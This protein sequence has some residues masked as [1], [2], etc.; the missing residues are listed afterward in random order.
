MYDKLAGPG[1]SN[2]VDASAD[3]VCRNSEEWKEFFHLSWDEKSDQRRINISMIYPKIILFA[4]S[5]NDL[6]GLIILI[7]ILN[8]VIC[9]KN[10]KNLTIGGCTTFLRHLFSFLYTPIYILRLINTSNTL[11]TIT[12]PNL[13]L[14]ILALESL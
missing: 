14:L 5:R 11:P 4:S 13:S 9:G 7:N 8:K 3:S 2:Y 10:F 6:T 12:R 1:S